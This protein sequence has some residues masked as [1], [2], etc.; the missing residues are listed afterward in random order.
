MR[1]IKTDLGR[2][3]EG[4]IEEVISHR[5]VQLGMNLRMV[6][7]PKPLNTQT[8]REI[9]A[10]NDLCALLISWIQNGRSLTEV[11]PMFAEFGGRIP[12]SWVLDES[13]FVRT[14][15][16]VPPFFPRQDHFPVLTSQLEELA[17]LTEGETMGAYWFPEQEEALSIVRSHE[18]VIRQYAPSDGSWRKRPNEKSSLYAYRVLIDSMSG[19]AAK[20]LAARAENENWTF[21]EGFEAP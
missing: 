11:R 21:W 14:F 17:E 9:D 7:R 10:L 12:D 1:V 20:T 4:T 15:V 16:A 5:L 18:Q 6:D 3:V 8:Q 19:W 13:I 2:G